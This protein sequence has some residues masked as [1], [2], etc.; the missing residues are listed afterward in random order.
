LIQR[1]G[2]TAEKL[3]EHLYLSPIFEENTREIIRDGLQAFMEDNHLVAAHLL[4]PQTEGAI[5]SLVEKAGGSVLKQG[6]VGGLQLKLLDE[7]LRD[8]KTIEVLGEDMVL[9]FRILLT[10]PRGWNLRNNISHGMMTHDAFDATVSDRIVHALLCLA[11]VR[12]RNSA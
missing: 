8:Q 4:I 10:D 2:L 7:L 11:L 6:R 9:Y 1:F 3:V 5:R 12:E